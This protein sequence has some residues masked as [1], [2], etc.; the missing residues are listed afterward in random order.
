MVHFRWRLFRR[1]GPMADKKWW[2]KGL[3][4]ENCSCQLVCPGHISFKQKCTYDRCI[5]CWAIHIHK[6][7]FQE[8]PLDGL[9]IVAVFDTPQRMYDGNWT[10]AFY[11]DER[12]DA[13]QR[14]ALET[15]YSG[16]AGGPWEILSGFVTKRL[17][18]RFVPI[19]YEEQGREKRMWIDDFFDTSVSAI[20]SKDDVG[21]VLL[22]NLFNQIHGTT[23]V[24]A[25]GQTRCSDRDFQ[26]QL[27]GSHSTYSHFAWEVP[28]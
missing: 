9:N 21:E 22:I 16:R 13:K 24:L 12:A 1:G 18:T 6:G 10:Q 7:A 20:R 8:T 17:D 2:A 27:N 26:F 15:I 25:R 11:M 5:G 19:H 23:Q 3:I 14:E 28:A 4:F